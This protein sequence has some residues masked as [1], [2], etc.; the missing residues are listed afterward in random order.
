ML[1]S[2][3][4]STGLDRRAGTDLAP[5]TGRRVVARTIHR[6]AAQVNEQRAGEG[7]YRIIFLILINPQADM[8]KNLL[9]AGWNAVIGRPQ[10]G[11]G[12]DQPVLNGF[13]LCSDYGF[14]P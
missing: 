9:K 10:S 8:I 6:R 2:S 3:A 7:D 1:P 11:A 5:F 13:G 4:R 12:G 14:Q